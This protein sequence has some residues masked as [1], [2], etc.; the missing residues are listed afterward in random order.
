ML[1]AMWNGTKN[2]I[3]RTKVGQ[4]PRFL[5]RVIYKEENY[6]IGDMD[7]KIK[8]IKSKDDKE[9]RDIR[10]VKIDLTELHN[11]LK[12]EESKI[13]RVE[14]EANEDTNFVV[15]DNEYLGRGVVKAFKDVGGELKT[16]DR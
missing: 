12:R 11:A 2:L 14:I 13:E 9:L 6:H 4:M 5:L 3:T 15:D 7:K 8:L 10:D 1:D 16:L